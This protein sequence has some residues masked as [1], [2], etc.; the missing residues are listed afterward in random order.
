MS[1]DQSCGKV[2]ELNDLL[3][4]IDRGMAINSLTDLIIGIGQPSGPGDFLLCKLIILL[5]TISGIN[6]I[7]LDMRGVPVGSTA[8]KEVVFF[9]GKNA[10]KIIIE[11]V[12][13][14]SIRT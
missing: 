14:F 6:S 4:M 11:Q 2:P 13:H 10:R 5:Q 8:G 7:E 3:N 9:I 12:C 1:L